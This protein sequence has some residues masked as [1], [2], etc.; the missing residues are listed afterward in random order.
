[1][2]QELHLDAHLVRPARRKAAVQLVHG[3]VPRGGPVDHFEAVGVVI[4][5]AA[6]GNDDRAEAGPTADAL[7]EV[8]H[9]LVLALSGP[10]RRDRKQQRHEKQRSN[11]VPEHPNTPPIGSRACLSPRQLGRPSLS[12][13]TAHSSFTLPEQ[14]SL[15]N[16]RRTW[17]P[18]MR[19]PAYRRIALLGERHPVSYREFLRSYLKG[20]WGKVAPF[21]FALFGGIA[22]QLLSPQV[23]RAF[24]DSAVA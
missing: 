13:Y 4:P 20:Q 23:I 18:G 3:P 10:N 17:Y 24:I 2:R 6:V 22:V 9:R 11:R 8:D 21:T 15:A 19:L 16:S 5:F 12:S 7:A 1:A 14:R